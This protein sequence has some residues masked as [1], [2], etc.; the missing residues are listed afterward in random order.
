[1]NVRDSPSILV[2]IRYAI[3]D[4]KRVIVVTAAN[5]PIATP[6]PVA[7]LLVLDIDDDTSLEL[8]SF[9]SSLSFSGSREVSGR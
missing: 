8:F 3:A 7:N 9:E 5:A 2:K 1:M 4:S 6:M